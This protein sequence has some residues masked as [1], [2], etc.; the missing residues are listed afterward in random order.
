MSLVR[1]RR[2][3]TLTMT[4]VEYYTRQLKARAFQAWVGYQFVHCNL[5]DSLYDLG[6]LATERK[7]HTVLRLDS[8]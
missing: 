8:T 5:M 6:C 1:M 4:V 7:R 2:V 3:I